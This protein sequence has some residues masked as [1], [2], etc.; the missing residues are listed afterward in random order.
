LRTT[1]SANAAA[2]AQ[3]QIAQ[4]KVPI[5]AQIVVNSGQPRPWPVIP[6]PRSYKHANAAFSQQNAGLVVLQLS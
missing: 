2:G 5:D 3:A 6:L 4:L 1:L